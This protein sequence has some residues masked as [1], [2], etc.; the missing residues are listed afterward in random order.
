MTSFIDNES[1]RN[2][3]QRPEKVQLEKSILSSFPLNNENVILSMEN[4]LLSEDLDYTNKLV[5]I[6]FRLC[7]I[8]FKT[9]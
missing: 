4:N 7:T 9:S 2:N 6:M 3:N 1:S 8:Y 5:K